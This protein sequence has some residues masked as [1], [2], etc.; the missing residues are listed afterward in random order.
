MII[1]FARSSS[2]SNY[3]S[4][5]ETQYYLTYNLGIL[6]GT[7]VRTDIGSATHLVLECLAACKK[8]IQDNPKETEIVVNNSTIGELRIPKKDLYKKS[9]LGIRATSEINKSRADKKRYCHD[10]QLQE[11]TQRI[12]AEFVQELIKRSSY[13][14]AEKSEKQW[15]AKDF[16]EVQNFTWMALEEQDG[17]FDPRNRIIVEPERSFEIPFTQF[18]WAKY[19]YDVQGEKLE[20][21]F[22]IKGTIDLI[23]QEEDDK[24]TYHI[25][26]WKT[27]SRKNWGTGQV[28]DY[29]Y[30]KN[31]TQLMLYYYAARKLYPDKDIFFT[32]FFIRDGGPYTICF[33]DSHLKVV[34]KKLEKHFKHV[35]ENMFPSMIHSEQKD[36]RCNRLC[37]YYKNKWSGTNE[38]I[39]NFI[40]RQLREKGMKQTTDL[41]KSKDFKIGY[42]EE[43]G[44]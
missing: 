40:Q 9:K 4:Y 14:F 13:Y 19:S 29:E 24:N 16:T 32:I 33:N 6:A 23:T 8:F 5:C 44:T 18:P 28:K 21:Y 43:P 30:L 31:D 26:D 25:I 12:G 34:E 38:N 11:G 42:Y 7:N 39:C 3:E 37:H 2:L 20:G 41:F 22:G 17:A 1:T 27:G 10:V 15:E 35:Q 36:F